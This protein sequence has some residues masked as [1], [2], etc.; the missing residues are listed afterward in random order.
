MKICINKIMNTTGVKKIVLDPFSYRQWD[1]TKTTNV[2]NFDKDKFTEKINQYYLD[3]PGSLKDGYAPFCKHIFI[4]NFTDSSANYVPI[5]EDN[6]G[7]IQT[8]YEARTEK[9]LPVLRRYI[10]FD[11]VKL[12][13]SKYLDII[14]YS[15]EQI[16]KEDESM[17][18]EDV[19]KDID[20]EYGI[21][22]VKPQ[23]NDHEL[24]MDPITMMRNALGTDQGGSGV[25][26]DRNKYM[27]SVK[28][29]TNNVILK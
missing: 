17:G 4:E 9:E 20:Y 29:W 18:N 7:L 25:A 3:N 1:S 10:P 12:S 27:D 5:T 19:N 24:P 14:L 26:L 16:Q 13:P 21:I 2:I 23:D 28:F 15:K 8:C 11:K 22:S 6:Q